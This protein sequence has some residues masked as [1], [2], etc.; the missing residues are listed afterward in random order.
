MN[1]MSGDEKKAARAAYK[2]RKTVPGIYAVRCGA[3]GQVWVGHAPDVETIRNR[4]WFALGMGKTRNQALDA[5]CAAHGLDSF[6]F[7]Q[8]E[9]IEE[10]EQMAM[11]YARDVVLKERAAFWRAKLEALTI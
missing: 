6:A 11:A 4:L 3:S 10:D 5:A 8:L 2:Q 7:E 9:R 1:T